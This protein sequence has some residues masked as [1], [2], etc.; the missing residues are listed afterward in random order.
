MPSEVIDVMSRFR[1]AI[2]AQQQAE[3]VRMA[4]AWLEVSRGL[5]LEFERLAREAAAAAA[6]GR[7]LSLW[8]VQRMERY[9]SLLAQIL[10]EQR[11]FAPVAADEIAQTQQLL[12]RWAITH[13][14]QLV[15]MQRPVVAGQF[16]RLPVDAVTNMV[17]SAG[18]GT[19]LADLLRA[20]FGA[21]GIHAGNALVRGT[22]L[23]W[24][25]TRVARAMRDEVDVTLEQAL[26]I[27]RTEELR[28]YREASRQQYIASGVVEGYIRVAAKSARTCFPAGTM[29]ATLSGDKRIEQLSPGELVWTGKGRL[30]PISETLKRDYD[31]DSIILQTASGITL[32]STAEH[33]ILVERQGQLQWMAAGDI[34]IG[35]RVV[36]GVKAGTNDFNHFGCDISIKRRVWEAH[37]NVATGVETESFAPIAI[38]SFMPVDTVNLQ[39]NV[40]SGQE[41]I[42]GVAINRSLLHKFN[43]QDGQCP[44]RICF[45]FGFPLMATIAGGA[46]KLLVGHRGDNTELFSAFLAGVYD[47]W[48]ATSFRAI[49]AV[50]S[51]A[52]SLAAPGA[53]MIDFVGHLP[54]TGATATTG[55]F[56]FGWIE[57]HNFAAISTGLFDFYAAVEFV[58]GAA[59]KGTGSSCAI[60][61][62]L[63]TISAG[64]L[65]SLTLIDS[66]TL[67]ATAERQRI[68][69]VFDVR[70]WALKILAAYRAGYFEAL[71]KNGAHSL[72]S[73]IRTAIDVF[74]FAKGRRGTTDWCPTDGAR[75]NH[76][77]SSDEWVLDTDIIT[78]VTRQNN[79]CASVYNLE[80]EDDHTYFANDILVHNCMACLMADGQFYE[81]SVPFEEHPAGR[82]SS[83]PAVRG[84]PPLVYETGEQ[85]F[86]RQDAVTQRKMMGPGRYAAWQEGRFALPDLVTVR[87]DDR[88]GNSLQ[89][90]PLRV[91]AARP[92]G[93]VARA[94]SSV[95]SRP[96]VP[97]TPV[98][99]LRYQV[100]DRQRALVDRYVM[101]EIERYARNHGLPVADVYDAVMGTMSELVENVPISI[102]YRHADLGGLQN[103][104]RF[105]S[106]FETG[107]SGG[108]FAPRER[109]DAELKGLGYPVNVAPR[110]RPLYGHYNVTGQP[111]RAAL[112][113]GKL[114]FVL[115]PELRQRATFTMGDS[116]AR[117]YYDNAYGAS[118]IAPEVGAADSHIVAIMQYVQDRDKARLVSNIAYIEAQVQN[119][120]QLGDVAY[121]IDHAAELTVGER[122]WLQS[123][124]IG[125]R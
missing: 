83:A 27:A 35:D 115:K 5:D 64:G 11:R 14:Q 116:L 34:V 8:H 112:N 53:H 40:E 107:R 43:A 103:T 24:H 106:Q 18:D 10:T 49:L 12:G 3:S 45:R 73:T 20:S 119:G 51:P 46:T 65:T 86:M 101:G 109:A 32:T 61:K 82:C 48:A 7:S 54:L 42:N 63:T 76:F 47:W 113:Y 77:V 4:R 90:T 58:T 59:T 72:L 108:M 99:T 66:A 114:E 97:T 31:G 125:V 52:E 70:R 95:A 118:V 36:R 2:D 102:N 96:S 33:P 39:G 41:E 30:R 16:D 80:V 85:W 87:Q 6:G 81:L 26:L 62:D 117:F 88:W 60:P 123:I 121:V 25:P 78:L 23:G 92:V 110:E 79:P 22:A 1:A 124:G 111:V 75:L 94:A 28:V 29:I 105:L 74:Q 57:Q 37:D 15:T 93:S 69:V 84:A 71:R 56:D 21:E 67:V 98:V 120:V 44:T 104:G 100:S 13:S 19:P 122:A 89:V 9:Q 68:A 55:R 50:L 38:G 91:L 17:G